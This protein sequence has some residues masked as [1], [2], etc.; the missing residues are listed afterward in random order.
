MF[1]NSGEVSKVS[2]VNNIFFQSVEY[3]AAW[4]MFDPWT[5][6]ASHN[7]A[8]CRPP[9]RCGWNG[10]ITIREDYNSWYETRPGLGKSLIVLGDTGTNWS[11]YY[12]LSDAGLAAYR[13]DTGNGAHS[14]RVD[15]QLLGLLPPDR[16]VSN[17]TN[18][19]PAATSPVLGVGAPGLLWRRDFAGKPIPVD[20]P[21]I[22]A[23]G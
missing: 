11:R 14:L 20:K 7:P 18:V 16:S 22:G 6:P 15:P 1:S 17:A 23:F 8:Y 21:N 2:I 4:W 13:R 3:E 9:R 10:P 19:R 5:S 12:N